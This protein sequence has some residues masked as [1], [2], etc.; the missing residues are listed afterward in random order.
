MGQPGDARQ[1]NRGHEDRRKATHEEEQR[2]PLKGQQNFAYSR[3]NALVYVAAS[4]ADGMVQA[5]EMVMSKGK[6]PA[7]TWWIEFENGGRSTV[8][9]SEAEAWAAVT[10]LE[11]SKARMILLRRRPTLL[12]SSEGLRF[13]IPV[14]TNR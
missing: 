14:K 7:V 5:D 6:A 11:S 2:R 1:D 13:A 4:Q 8:Y 12:V 10:Y 3:H 9:A